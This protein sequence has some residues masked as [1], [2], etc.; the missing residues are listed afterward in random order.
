MSNL[1]RWMYRGGRPNA[2]ARALNGFQAWLGER[3]LLPGIMATLQVPG[4]K[5][6][7]LV[8]FPVVV[9]PYAGGQYLVSMLGAETNWVKN[10]HAAAGRVTL[11]RGKARPATLVELPVEQRAPVIKEFAMLAPGGRVHIPVSKDAPVEE[12]E[13][14][15]PRYPVFLVVW[16]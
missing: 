11:V 15:A 10:V 12:F 13:S 4:R 5:S 14:V 16:D 1:N 6:G 2:L 3:G 8:R 7:K 9:T